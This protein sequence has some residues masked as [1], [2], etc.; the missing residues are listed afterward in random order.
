M[1]SKNAPCR[2][3][4]YSEELPEDFAERVNKR[5]L[6]FEEA[7]N[8][9]EAV[10]LGWCNPDNLFDDN[11]MTYAGH[12]YVVGFVLYKRNVSSKALAYEVKRRAER[13]LANTG[14][15]FVS[16]ERKKEIKE[17]VTVEFLS[18]TPVQ[19]TITNVIIDPAKHLLYVY[20]SSN[21]VVDN[22]KQLFEVTAANQT[23][24]YERSAVDFIP[25]EEDLV[26][27]EEYTENF[28]TWLWYTTETNS[29]KSY[30]SGDDM[31]SA[32][33]IVPDERIV[34]GDK[35]S[36]ICSVNGDIR[37]ARNG[38]FNGKSVAKFSFSLVGDYQKGKTSGRMETS[39]MFNKDFFFN[40]I[41]FSIELFKDV[42][43]NREEY[44]AM[45]V[46]ETT[47]HAYNFV[48]TAVRE[49]N[50]IYFTDEWKNLGREI[51]NWSRGDVC[52]KAFSD[53]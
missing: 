2:V 43:D 37:E 26:D 33:S 51:W 1:F 16:R 42:V 23:G 15:R 13:E 50:K 28:L 45:Y 29:F 24:V 21:K 27:Y 52:I 47:E 41:E 20:S 49:F 40:K 36:G 3:L 8:T 12:L 30:E 44:I 6:T 46:H 53:V 9:S 38:I 32:Y 31:Q 48:A 5:C 34:V 22:V 39:C 18:K 19:P 10:M 7:R 14:K 25:P 11:A 35:D 17:Q 4:R